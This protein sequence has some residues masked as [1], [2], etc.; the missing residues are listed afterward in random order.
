[1][2]NMSGNANED[3]HA[4]GIQELSRLL[5]QGWTM[6]AESCPRVGCNMPLMRSRQNR[7]FCCQC[8]ADILQPSTSTPS[9]TA[10]T[11]VPTSTAVVRYEPNAAA[12]AA[13]ING[14]AD[15]DTDAG[16]G[17]L[18]VHQH[19]PNGTLHGKRRRDDN[20]DEDD[21][22]DDDEDDDDHYEDGDA[23]PAAAGIASR[24]G[25]ANANV[26]VDNKDDGGDDNDGDRDHEADV[27]TD[28]NSRRVNVLTVAT[29]GDNHDHDRDGDQHGRDENTE[30]RMVVPATGPSGLTADEL[31]DKLLEGWALVRD[32]DVRGLGSPLNTTPQGHDQQMTT[33]TPVTAATAT[34]N[35]G[36][37]VNNTNPTRT[38]GTTTPQGHRLSQLTPTG[39]ART[40]TT[41]TTTTNNAAAVRGPTTTTPTT[42]A[43]TT[44]TAAAAA[45]A[46]ARHRHHH[47]HHIRHPHHRHALPS[48]HHHH[49]RHRPR[50]PAI[51]DASPSVLLPSGPPATTTG[52]DVDVENVDTDV[53]VDQELRLAE[54]AAA[55]N[56]RVLRTSLEMARDVETRQAIT[57]AMTESIRTIEAA[58]NALYTRTSL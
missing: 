54:L 24:N 39:R 14:T 35:N 50:I 37:N 38:A 10:A 29:T 43:T 28:I 21:D 5:L 31:D 22:V 7:I 11:G 48:G 9:S 49:Q 56:L 32:V 26:N 4:A 13:A 18:N 25:T 2:A 51:G 42:T 20:D 52:V 46:A 30:S 41:T 27:D 8:R 40:T 6:L 12:T 45:S 34:P 17:A 36:N 44:T 47:H 1:M 19:V 57:T 3:S 58:R 55:T 15:T 23:S 53:N 16:T 33:T